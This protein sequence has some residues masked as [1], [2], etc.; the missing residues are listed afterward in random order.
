VVKKIFQGSKICY[1]FKSQPKSHI[2][3]FKSLNVEFQLLNYTNAEYEPQFVSDRKLIPLHDENFPFR[4]RSNTHLAAELCRAGFQF[5]ILNDVF[6]VHEG[7][8]TKESGVEL[9]AKKLAIKNGYLQVN[10]SDAAKLNF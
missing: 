8:K 6:S 1:F 2:L 4:H 10:T 3:F 7:I 5:A 9:A